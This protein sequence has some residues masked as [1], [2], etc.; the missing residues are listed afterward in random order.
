MFEYEELIDE[1]QSG[2]RRAQRDRELKSVLKKHITLEKK[3][4]NSSLGK[5]LIR[6][7]IEYAPNLILYGKGAKTIKN[8][9]IRSALQSDIAS[10]AVDQAAGLAHESY[11]IFCKYCKYCK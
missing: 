3:V 11:S 8:K 2:K 10:F 5:R 7:E 9:R 1:K 4:L 6:E